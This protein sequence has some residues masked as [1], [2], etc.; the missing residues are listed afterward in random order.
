MNNYKRIEE[1]KETILD[2]LTSAWSRDITRPDELED[3]ADRITD[4]ECERLVIYYTDCW[5]IC[6][7]AQK[8]HFEIEQTGRKAENICQLAFWTLLELFVEA[9]DSTELVSQVLED[10]E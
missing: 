10:N 8:S 9:Y 5:D 7:E 6:R 2:E 3:L 1:I 4:Q